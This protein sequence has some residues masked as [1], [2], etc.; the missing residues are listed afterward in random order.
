MSYQQKT[1]FKAI[2]CWGG[3]VEDVATILRSTTDCITIPDL[4]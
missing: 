1:A 4:R 3:I 2:F